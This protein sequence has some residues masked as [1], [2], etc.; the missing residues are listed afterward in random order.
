MPSRRWQLKQRSV[1]PTEPGSESRV[2]AMSAFPRRIARPISPAG[3]SESGGTGRSP[4][5]VSI[6]TAR[7]GPAR[8][9]A[10]WGVL[11]GMRCSTRQAKTIP[12]TATRATGSEPRRLDARKKTLRR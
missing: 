12:T 1:L 2:L 6:A 9:G 8:E 11:A 10:A 4:P 7:D 5:A 3:I